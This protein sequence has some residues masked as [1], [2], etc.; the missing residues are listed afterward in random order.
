MG[1]VLMRLG[2][3]AFIVRD[4]AVLLVAFDDASGF[5]YNLPGGGVKPGESVKAGLKREVFEETRAEVEVGQLLMVSEYQPERHRNRYGGVH[6]LTLVFACRLSEASEAG[7]PERPD[8]EQVDVLWL[9]L[10]ELA[11]APLIPEV[12][13]QL[14]ARLSSPGADVYSDAL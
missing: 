6:K 8:P 7:F 5:H 10:T 11:T 12:F 14:P 1:K 2:A 13:R 3:N 4:G 9:P